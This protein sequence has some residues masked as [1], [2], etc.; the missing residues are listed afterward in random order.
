MQEQITERPKQKTPEI[1]AGVS[2][3]LW[4]DTKLQVCEVG[5]PRVEQGG[6]VSATFPWAGLVLTAQR[7]ESVAPWTQG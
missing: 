5:P 2:W 1:H 4:L 7:R 6:A 3:S